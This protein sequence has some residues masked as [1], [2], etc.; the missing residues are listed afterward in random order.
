MSNIN[1]SDVID[2]HKS[3][4]HFEWPD[5]A[6]FL[7]MLAGSAAIGIYFGFRGKTSK[8]KLVRSNDHDDSE[9]AQ[10]YLMGGRQMS[11]IPVAVSLVAR[12]VFIK[13]IEV[14]VKASTQVVDFFLIN[15]DKYQNIFL[16]FFSVL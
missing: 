15:L 6:V 7:L 12:Y 5:Y 10:E 3:L 8:S 11:V 14:V 1:G 16:L 2:L 4:Q 13:G 9:V